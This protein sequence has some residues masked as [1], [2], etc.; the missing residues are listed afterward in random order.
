MAVNPKISSIIKSSGSTGINPQTRAAQSG[1]GNT[2]NYETKFNYSTANNETVLGGNNDNCYIVLGKD[3]I[4]SV[5]S[6]YGGTGDSKSSK[7]DIVV[8]RIS[9]ISNLE[10][11]ALYID[12]NFTL[13]AARIYISQKTDVDTNFGL[14]DGQVGNAKAKSAIALKADGLRFIAREGIKLV[15]KTDPNN[16]A[17]VEISEHSGIDLIANNDD[18]KLQPMVLGE[19]VVNLLTEL[20]TEIDN[21]SN[22]LQF[23]IDEQQKYN[24]EIAT[25]THT[26]VHGNTPK[27]T[28]ISTNL[29]IKNGFLTVK[30]LL[31][32]DTGYY[33]QK[34]NL[35]GLIDKYLGN[36][37]SSIKSKYNRVN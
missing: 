27:N 35:F 22:R 16:S 17:G 36:G 29:A 25:H 4:S 32:F 19:N 15:T 6:G 31:D 1:I 28:I 37:E 33:F 12:S 8:G 34:T 23:F 2:N 7:I 20:I 10:D 3:R 24:N 18:S 5:F 9:A 11:Q 26:Y 30:K 21:L 14:V 13:D